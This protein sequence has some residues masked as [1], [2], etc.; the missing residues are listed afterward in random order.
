MRTLLAGGFT[1]A[2]CSVNWIHNALCTKGHLNKANCGPLRVSS[3]KPFFSLLVSFCSISLSSCETPK[4]GCEDERWATNTPFPHLNKRGEGS[5]KACVLSH[6]CFLGFCLYGAWWENLTTNRDTSFKKLHNASHFFTRD[7]SGQNKQ[8]KGNFL[9]QIV[10]PAAKK[11][12]LSEVWIPFAF[13][14]FQI[15]FCGQ[16]QEE[17]GSHQTG[18]SDRT[19]KPKWSCNSCNYPGVANNNELKGKCHYKGKR[20]KR[21]SCVADSRWS[22]LETTFHAKLRFKIN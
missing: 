10:L 14:T 18:C 9:S 22:V 3:S 16:F 13:V 2:W 7:K 19:G 8:C 1:L 4:G 5:A 20:R 11:K 12:T 17:S 6:P 15:S 21:K